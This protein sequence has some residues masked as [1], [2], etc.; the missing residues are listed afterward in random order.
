MTEVPQPC[1]L[2]VFGATG[3]LARRKLMPALFR[4]HVRGLLPKGFAVLGASRRPLSHDQF[5]ALMREACIQFSPTPPSDEQWG[6]FAERLYY[7]TGHFTDQT[8]FQRLNMSLREI[9]H[10]HETQGNRVF[11]LATL[12]SNYPLLVRQFRGAEMVNKIDDRPFTRLIVEKPFGHDLD[13]AIAL[14]DEIAT[15]FREDQ[16]YRIDHYLG[17][18]T[19]QNIL[20]F[21]FANAIFEPLWNRIHIDH[22]QITAAETLGI[23]G[24]GSYY[25]ETGVL[26]D[27]V[28]N[29]LLQIVSLVAMEPPL[30]FDADAIRDKRAEV[31]R[32]L[33]R[34]T[35][36]EDIA[37]A[38]VRGQYGPSVDGSLKAYRAEPGVD[39]QSPVPTYMALRVF[40]DNWRWQG[41]P[42]YIRTGKHLR[43]STSVVVIQ[44]RQIPFCLFGQDQVR[45]HIEPNR[46]VLRIQ[47]HE[48]IS[49][50][51]SIKAPGNETYVDHTRM[52]FT[53]SN[54][55]EG[56]MPL[57]YERL[58]TDVMRGY[59]A[60]FARRDSVEEAW[61]FVTPILD[62]WTQDPAHD[63]P[64][65]AADSDGPEAANALLE[66]DGRSWHP[67]DPP[68]PSS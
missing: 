62:A 46:L 67:L 18:E 9:D 63:F 35:G 3:D 53:Y 55:Y 45:S 49:L 25:E 59:A 17:K 21:R 15:V 23:E 22:V 5:R 11:Y 47:P 51:F 19:V 68:A 10:R 6:S 27:M 28:Q 61:R 4:L 54:Y 8:L 56:E 26:R 64:N 42:F 30:S 1:V 14:N 32:A 12:P 39:P 44:F 2:L 38:T 48:G 43:R 37:A 7:E 58:L 66:A 16:V 57:A 24:R 50:G 13:S 40:V 20:V 31:F 41:V 33:R 36:P 60:L 65:Y 29:H 52:R 34:F